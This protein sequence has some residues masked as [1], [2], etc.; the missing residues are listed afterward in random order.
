MRNWYEDFLTGLYKHIRKYISDLLM[1]TDWKKYKI[2]FLF[3]FP[4]TWKE[5]VI[6]EFRNIVNEAGF[7]KDGAGFE[8]D[9][10]GHSVHIELTE[11]EAAAVYAA[12]GPQHH[13]PLCAWNG[14]SA[15]TNEFS[16]DG[17]NVREGDVILVCNS[18]SGTTVCA[19]KSSRLDSH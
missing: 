6:E 11:A 2:D 14:D 18:D 7:G 8:Q 19:T 3:S 1:L 4:T 12:A 15:S 10:M 5:S 17:L 16:I 9:G 13:K